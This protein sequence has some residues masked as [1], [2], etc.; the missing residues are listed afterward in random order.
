MGTDYLDDTLSPDEK[1]NITLNGVNDT[2]PDHPA[3][4]VVGESL[5]VR[6]TFFEHG[7]AVEN[8]PTTSLHISDSEVVSVRDLEVRA[9][10]TG[11]AH[12]FAY[13]ELEGAMIK[14]DAIFLRV[15]S[16]PKVPTEMAIIA[17]KSEEDPT[18]VHG[19]LPGDTVFF[20]LAFLNYRGERIDKPA[21][22]S[23]WWHSKRPDVVRMIAQNGTATGLGS[24]EIQAS[25]G[26]LT[27]NSWGLNVVATETEVASITIVPPEDSRLPLNSSLA[28]TAMATD[29]N[30]EVI[31]APSLVWM[32][33]VAAVASVDANGLVTGH[34]VGTAEV[35][36]R[37][38]PI[39]SPPLAVQVVDPNRATQIVISGNTAPLE[40]GSTRQLSARVTNVFG[41]ALNTTLSWQ[42]SHENVATVDENGLL[43]AVAAGMSEITAWAGETRST[44][45]QAE[46]ISTQV[47]RGQLVSSSSYTVEGSVMLVAAG[48]GQ[49]TITFGS[50][51]ML[52]RGPGVELFLSD[53]KTRTR[54]AYQVIQRSKKYSGMYEISFTASEDLL[55][56]PYVVFHCVPFNVT[57]GYALLE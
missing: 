51:F 15:L 20:R 11:E 3:Q 34:S 24:T 36:V 53:K 41:N 10:R 18:E 29:V 5:R 47:R 39:V 50:D 42:S 32:S 6:V 13:V 28:L 27:S 19:L 56:Y 1:Y 48:E 49:Y 55:D 9:V 25:Y 12:I 46:V 31:T 52:S 44:P 57:F 26:Q 21:E 22:G 7:R 43:Q 37:I 23:V 4:L 38:G 30:N 8:P 40:V 16:D 45:Y 35:I 2:S 17:Q 33:R 14:S 54:A